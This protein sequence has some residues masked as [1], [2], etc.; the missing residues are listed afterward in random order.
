MRKAATQPLEPPVKLVSTVTN[1]TMECFGPDSSQRFTKGWLL[2]L[3][4]G[5]SLW[6]Q[7]TGTGSGCISDRGALNFDSDEIQPGR[8]V[9]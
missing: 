8:L 2:Q 7:K 6:G 9:P 5:A 1:D 3:P 4:A